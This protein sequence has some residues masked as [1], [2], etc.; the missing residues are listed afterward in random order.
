MSRIALKCAAASF[1]L[2]AAC[3]AL[4]SEIIP[5]QPTAFQDV[6]LRMT[7]DSCAFNAGSVDV[8]ALGDAIRVTQQ[9]NNCLVVGTPR[10]VDVRL[11]ALPAGNWR[12]EVY[13]TPQPSG[14]PAER[15]AFTV[16]TPAVIAIFPA[17]PRPLTG[18]GGMW[19]NDQESGWGLSLHQGPTYSLL[20]TLFVYD[21]NGQ[22]QW[23]SIQPGGWTHET[24]WQGT[25]YRTSGP[26]F[27]VAVYN[28]LQVQVL[29]VGSAT[30]DFEQVAGSLGRATFTYT[31]N[32]VSTTKVI[33][34][35]G[36]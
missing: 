32:G 29:A 15:L 26:Y 18:Y 10:V 9:L 31:V 23:Y 34:R 33:T 36:L 24:R 11:G 16:T 35:L 21:G 30:L 27:G 25:V 12:V 7:V 20:G 14:T 28:P 22:P 6:N 1:A 19:W 13:T 2:A 8:S 4:A 3:P 17:P 5:S